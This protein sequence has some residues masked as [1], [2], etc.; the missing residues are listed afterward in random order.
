MD[1]AGKKLVAELLD[2]AV[3]EIADREIQGILGSLS[4]SE[5]RRRLRLAT[6]SLDKLR[7]N[8][9]PDYS[10]E[11]VAAMYL[12]QYQLQHIN[13]AYSMITSSLRIGGRRK[14]TSGNALHVVDYGCGALAMRFGVLLAVADALEAGELISAVKVESLDPA[15]PLVSLGASIWARFKTLLYNSN[16]EGLKWIK[17][18][19]DLFVP[20][21]V[22]VQE[23]VLLKDIEPFTGADMWLS[24]IHV[25][26]GAEETVRK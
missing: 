6:F 26:E 2:H 20:S 17:L 3:A 11:L 14:V 12:V 24:A 19:T 1:L 16:Q 7:K 10:D 22:S 21:D 15:L 13:L 8:G 9:S 23:S 18:A 4:E 25:V 5:K